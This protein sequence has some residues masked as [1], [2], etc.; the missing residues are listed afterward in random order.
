MICV[1]HFLSR[2]K[3]F[4]FI[5][6]NGKYSPLLAD[7]MHQLRCNLIR[8]HLPFFSFAACSHLLYCIGCICSLSQHAS[9]F[10]R[11]TS[12]Q[13]YRCLD[14]TCCHSFKFVFPAHF[15]LLRPLSAWLLYFQLVFTIGRYRSTPFYNKT[16]IKNKINHWSPL[17]CCSLKPFINTSQ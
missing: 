9:L 12:E 7:S 6:L 14:L 11:K 15:S 2:A 16:I 10:D 8:F 13:T 17:I 4:T 5:F 1:L 3:T